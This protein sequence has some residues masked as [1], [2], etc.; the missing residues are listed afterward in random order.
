MI[1]S[2]KKRIS[3]ICM[4]LVGMGLASC[5]IYSFKDVS[6]PAQVKSIHIGYI[7][8]RAR[9]VDPQLAPQLNDKLRQ[10]I[11]SQASKLAQLQTPDADYDVTGT[12]T[13]YSVTTSGISNQRAASNRLSVTVHLIFKNHLDPSGKTV[14]P[15]DFEADVTRNFDFDATLTL[16]DAG[17]KL[18][19][20]IVT[21]MTDEIFNK[22]FSNW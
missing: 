15:A 21:N 19:P 17:P 8:N 1:S 11:S 5:K 18:L 3:F 7:E 22:L 12:I 14:A 13:D 10:K 6:I 20:D 2:N 16:T 9:Y 4:A